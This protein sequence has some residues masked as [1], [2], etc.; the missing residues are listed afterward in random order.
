MRYAAYAAAIVLALV[1]VL[2]AQT[3]LAWG[4]GVGIFGALALIG[5]IDLLQKR[6]TLRRNYP[7][8]A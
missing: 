8:R 2:L 5:T 3:S 7:L 6:S 4:W 1:S